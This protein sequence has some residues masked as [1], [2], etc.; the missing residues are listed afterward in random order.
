MHSVLKEK[1]ET[2][3]MRPT[4]LT[5]KTIT[6]PDFHRMIMLPKKQNRRKHRLAGLT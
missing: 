2:S 1:S 4:T 3:T 6:I 5:R